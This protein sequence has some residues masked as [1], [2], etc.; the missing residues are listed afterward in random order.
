MP[1]EELKDVGAPVDPAKVD[2]DGSKTGEVGT[3]SSEVDQAVNAEQ[4]DT[5]LPTD[6]KDFHNRFIAQKKIRGVVKGEDGLNT[7]TFK[8]NSTIVLPD[9]LLTTMVSDGPAESK[10]LP[11]TPSQL[12]MMTI[13]DELEVLLRDHYCLNV[14]EVDRFCQYL[15]N[16]IKN[17]FELATRML[18]GGKGEYLISLSAVNKVLKDNSEKILEI[19]RGLNA[20]NFVERQNKQATASQ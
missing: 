8:D 6:P 12:R 4:D 16:V 19:Q 1:D 9:C 15:S 18:W 7:V 13:A 14:G 11:L 17:N 20:D 5:A 3:G 10:G 2:E